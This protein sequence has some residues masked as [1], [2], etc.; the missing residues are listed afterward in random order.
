MDRTG[1]VGQHM[2]STGVRTGEALDLA[3][4][5]VLLI[6][7]AY[8]LVNEERDTFGREALDAIVKGMEDYRDDLVVIMTGYPAQMNKLLTRNPGLQSRFA[9]E[10]TFPDYDDDE[11]LQILTDMAE[12]ADYDL[13]EGGEPLLRSAFAK[14]RAERAFGN[15]RYV[16]NLLDEMI[17]ELRRTQSA[18]C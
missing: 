15:A 3:R 11:L 6:D 2:G 1:L 18:W 10:I 12:D 14:A 4:G 9:A 7:E 13:P 16:R 5:G 17:S 8:S